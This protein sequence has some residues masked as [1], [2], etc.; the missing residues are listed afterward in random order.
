MLIMRT[1]SYLVASN[2]YATTWTCSP[3]VSSVHEISQQRILEWVVI[4]LFNFHF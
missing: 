2:S 1:I 4:A 3:P